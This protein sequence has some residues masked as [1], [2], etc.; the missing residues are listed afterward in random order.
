MMLWLNKEA[1]FLAEGSR[2]E[3]GNQTIAYVPGVQK[4]PS[5][6]K[7]DDEINPR[8]RLEMVPDTLRKKYLR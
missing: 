8:T 4:V 2:N 3:E 7:A 5:F 1:S 6:V